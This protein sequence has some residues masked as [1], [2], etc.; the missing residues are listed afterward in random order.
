MRFAFAR[1]PGAVRVFVLS[2]ASLLS[3][4]PASAQ[5]PP[6]RLDPAPLAEPMPA[7]SAGAALLIV[8]PPGQTAN[9]NAARG[10]PPAVAAPADLERLY[11][12]RILT[13]AASLKS[14]HTIRRLISSPSAETR[15]TQWFKES[16]DPLERSAWL[17]D[18]LRVTTIPGTALIQVE[19][20]DV[21]DS[22][23]RKTILYEICQTFLDSNKR[24]QQDALLDR[25][26]MLN[27]V[28]IKA[29]MRLK[30]L[31]QEMRAK[32]IQLNLD[33]G[34]IGRIGV[35]EMEL[36][37]LVGEHID[38]QM[39]TSRARAAFEV[40]SAAAQ[41]GNA[42]PAAEAAAEADPRVQ[43]LT[44]RLE[45]ARLRA[46]LARTKPGGA[47]KAAA[48][49]ADAEAKV[50]ATHAEQRRSSVAARAKVALLEQA[51]ARA[52]E[53]AVQLETL[54]KR[55]DNLKDALGELGNAMVQY[56]NLQEEQKG[57]REQ[58]RNVREQIE[59]LMAIQSSA[60]AS[61]VHWHQIP[62][63]G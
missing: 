45:D 21:R 2:I 8:D 36:S 13:C 56:N 17:R 57:L 23:E 10:T 50:L 63:P 30:D 32:Q 46:D 39:R 27:N 33:G 62:E 37:K 40:L 12:R 42:F 20:P 53:E 18:H 61:D 59:N 52:S 7:I 11:Q 31:N 22:R 9:V 35:K 60:A 3:A 25:T 24:V 28:R 6:A 29:D 48:E 38:A 54:T 49:E 44:R 14:E 5:V 1:H 26:S 51:Q 19:L 58:V 43:E 34:G 41:Q 16:D 47:D 15:K 55:I 4:G